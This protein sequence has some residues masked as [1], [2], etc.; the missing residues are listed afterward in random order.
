MWCYWVHVSCCLQGYIETAGNTNLTK[1]YNLLEDL[2]AQQSRYGNLKSHAMLLLSL[3]KKESPIY[4]YIFIGPSFFI[5][6]NKKMHLKAHS[7]V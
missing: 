3:M 5:I 1:H 4:I 6:D 2:N 7:S